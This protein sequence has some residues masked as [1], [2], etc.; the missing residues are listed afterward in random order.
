MFIFSA[1]RNL[2]VRSKVIASF[3]CVLAVTAGLGQFSV[4]SLTD[5]NGSAEQI[6]S[7]WLPATM[8]LGK[9]AASSNRYR[10]VQAQYILETAD[11]RRDADLKL[12]DGI[13]ADIADAEENYVPTATTTK[14]RGLAAAFH[15]KWQAYLALQDQL[16]ELAKKKGA[17]GQKATIKFYTETSKAPFDEFQ[18]ALDETLAFQ[19]VGANEAGNEGAAV[20]ESAHDWIYRAMGVAAFLSVL[21]GL[22]L[23]RA[24]SSPLRL[25]TKTMAELADGHLEV[26]I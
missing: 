9:I 10:Q 21:I 6:R 7:N 14:E 13:K 23:I 25:M 24:V 22:M 18:K 19:V 26:E 17:Q 20:F 12:L 8:Y 5:V 16:T 2:S 1:L 11:D 3:L 15:Q 4:Q